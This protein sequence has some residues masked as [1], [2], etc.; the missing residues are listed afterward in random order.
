MMD[1]PKILKPE[2]KYPLIV[3][4]NDI[5]W[6]RSYINNYIHNNL[7]KDKK[8]DKIFVGKF[9]GQGSTNKK[10]LKP[11]SILGC[12]SREM[13]ERFEINGYK[14]I[15]P[16]NY[17]I[18]DIIY[19]IRNAKELILSCGTCGHLYCPYVKKTTRVYWLLNIKSE[20]GIISDEINK[21]QNKN[22]HLKLNNDE[23]SKTSDIILRFLKDYRI[24]FYKYHPHFDA[25]VNS[26]NIYIG[27]DMFDFLEKD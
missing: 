19:Y 8:Y 22:S 20:M 13:L 4:N 7:K 11:R 17:N 2:N 10:I 14:N 1:S 12:V 9:E 5:Y 18:L 25:R 6:F 16:Y 3:Y 15:D 21:D 24:C 26:K 23:Y 27:E